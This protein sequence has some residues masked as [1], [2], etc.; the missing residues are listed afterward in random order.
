MMLANA[1]LM[2][3][4]EALVIDKPAGLPVDPPRAGGPSVTSL[5]PDDLRL[6][7]ARVPVAVHRLDRDTSGCLLLARTPKAM[8]RFQAAFEARLV[9]K[10]Y[11]A[12]VDG[13]PASENGTI[14]LPLRKISSQANGWRMIAAA[15]G[16]AAVT[17]W[18]MLAHHGGR[19]LIELT[20]QTGRTHQLRVHCATGLGC[21]ITGDGRYGTAHAA[22]MM[23][24][25]SA[26]TV[27]RQPKA[28]IS[29]AAPLPSRF[30]ALGLGADYG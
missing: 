6:G 30:T 23:L 17:D 27:P 12:I 14:T 5:A 19:T 1:I 4:A 20:P 29:A 8:R 11:L 16:Q 25:A 2:I 28:A 10:T 18:R 9:R 22:G 24:H 15:D 7:F 13:T 21:P 26:L 3:D